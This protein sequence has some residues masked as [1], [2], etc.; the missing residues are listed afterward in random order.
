MT[1]DD[2]NGATAKYGSEGESSPPVVR[3]MVLETDE[4]HPQSQERKGTYG[5]NLHR[6]F[7][8]AGD[9][10]KPRL[11]I[12]TDIRFV[13]ADKG[14][15]VPKASEFEGFDAVLLTGSMYDAHGDDD[16]I[17]D[18]K[19]LL[20]GWFFFL[21]ASRLL[22]HDFLDSNKHQ[23]LGDIWLNLPLTVPI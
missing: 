4:P 14:G 15:E 1:A 9:E 7:K 8:A 12:E 20:K 2:S 19:A 11:G 22:K 13:V 21:H 6:H 18:L 3:M 16:W 5:E 23:M 10:H 17:K